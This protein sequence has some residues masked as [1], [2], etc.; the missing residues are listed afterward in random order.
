MERETYFF[1]LT[2][3]SPGVAGLQLTG[4]VRQTTLFGSTTVFDGPPHRHLLLVACCSVEVPLES[5]RFFFL[6]PRT[7]LNQ[8]TVKIF[9]HVSGGLA[10]STTALI[11]CIGSLPRF[12]S[13]ATC[14]NLLHSGPQSA[15]HLNQCWPWLVFMCTG[16]GTSLSVWPWRPTTD[17]HIYFRP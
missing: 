13:F 12:L 10:T 5:S 17:H 6:A 7:A 8:N 1:F 2:K 16:C 9:H 15:K 3:D 14:P 11:Y 4:V